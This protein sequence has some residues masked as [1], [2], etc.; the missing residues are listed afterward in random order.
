[1]RLNEQKIIQ[2]ARNAVVGVAD[3][4][5]LNDVITA[6]KEALRVATEAEQAAVTA[7]TAAEADHK[8]ATR[9]SDKAAH[10]PGA[11]VMTAEL[12]VEQAQRLVRVSGKVLVGASNNRKSAAEAF[13]RARG[14]AHMPVAREG[15]QRIVHALGKVEAAREM[16]NEAFVAIRAGEHLLQHAK[17]NGALFRADHA[18]GLNRWIVDDNREICLAS[19]AS[20]MAAWVAAGLLEAPKV[21]G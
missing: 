15:A 7:A 2:D 21:E 13:E 4:L 20:E 14:E 17:T 10:T 8:R 16:L 19:A 1:M 6:A 11:D 18:A 3:G 5:V 12:A 9:A